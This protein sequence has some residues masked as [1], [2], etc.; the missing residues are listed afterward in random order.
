MTTK[1]RPEKV[2]QKIQIQQ[3]MTPEERK[4]TGVNHL[5]PGELQEL[6][7]WVNMNRTLLGPGPKPNVAGS[8]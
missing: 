8:G 4:A 5:S 3:M 6:N 2:S 7:H 1:H